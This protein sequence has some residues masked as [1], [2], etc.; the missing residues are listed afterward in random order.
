VAERL[1][2]LRF[3][4]DRKRANNGA[5]RVK[6]VELAEILVRSRQSLWILR[7]A[8]C[9]ADTSSLDIRTSPAP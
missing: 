2:P 6:I 8:S 7:A 1:D 4:S 3:V 5:T 9:G